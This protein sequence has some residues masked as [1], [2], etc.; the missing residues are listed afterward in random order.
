[1]LG[2]RATRVVR[3]RGGSAAEEQAL[4]VW[5]NP[6][7]WVADEDDGADGWGGR[8]DERRIIAD[9]I[10]DHRI[11]NLLMVSG[12][13]HMVAIDDGT[14]TD[15][16]IDGG[17]GF[18]LIHAAALDR[19]GSTKGGPYSEG[20]V[21]G[22]GQY[23]RVDIDDDGETIRVG[24]WRSGTTVRCCCRT[25]SRFPAA[26]AS[27]LRFVG[28]PADEVVVGAGRHRRRRRSWSRRAHRGY[29]RTEASGR[30]L[31]HAR[32]RLDGRRS[33]QPSG[34]P[35]SSPAPCR[36]TRRPAT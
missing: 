17:A 3:R 14:N 16:S 6:V 24:L 36:R 9:V 27:V 34:S 32:H 8:S 26:D 12:D 15:Y 25:T 22:G 33:T 20:E 13:A 1:M 11:D 30:R 4:V 5:V 29:V 18:P 23:G 31:H 35:C 2:A 7:P 28:P 21:T 19:P 10:A